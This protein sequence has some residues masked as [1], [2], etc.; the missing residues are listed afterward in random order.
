MIQKKRAA[1]I[2]MALLFVIQWLS[3]SSIVLNALA[4]SSA[5]SL[6]QG[7]IV[8]SESGPQEYTLLIMGAISLLASSILLITYVHIFLRLLGDRPLKLSKRILAFEIAL[9]LIV[10]A[11]WSTAS[12]IMLTR[13]N[14]FIAI[15]IWL[16]TLAVSVYSL[17]RLGNFSVGGLLTLQAP[18]HP[19][20]DV[21]VKGDP[22]GDSDDYKQY[23]VIDD[24]F[25]KT[26][27]IVVTTAAPEG[28]A[29]RQIQQQQQKKQGEKE[30]RK[31]AAADDLQHSQPQ[32]MK[33]AKTVKSWNFD[34]SF[35]PIH[36]DLM[37]PST[38]E[39][40]GSRKKKMSNIVNTYPSYP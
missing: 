6:D 10:I 37:L 8:A 3:I 2:Q 14:G 11:L 35:E 40:I 24:K 29:T 32:E 34:F 39:L 13:Y 25:T 1:I 20:E 4:L 38:S 16:V 27:A 19:Y 9:T 28:E 5:R 30:S 17:S 33:P 36:L 31:I 7:L 12:G 15:A 26:E 22:T 21:K 18:V 23:P